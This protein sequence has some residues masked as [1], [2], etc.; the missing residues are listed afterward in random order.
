MLR[1]AT[2]LSL[3]R[4]DDLS[5]IARRDTRSKSPAYRRGGLVAR[6]VVSMHAR[7]LSRILRARSGGDT[8]GAAMMAKF[9]RRVVWGVA[10]FLLMALACGHSVPDDGAGGGAATAGDA[11][12]SQVT[13]DLA[14]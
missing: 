12:G 14:A 9:G 5:V 4:Q 6:G 11:N 1:P 8:R 7:P 3:N 10:G 2:S 13:G